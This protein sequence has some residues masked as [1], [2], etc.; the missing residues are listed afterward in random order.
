MFNS[1]DNKSFKIKDKTINIRNGNYGPYIQIVSL[2]KTQNISIPH[3]YNL[4]TITIDD[5]MQ[6]IANKNNIIKNKK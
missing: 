1:H 2:N 5:I 4:E 6:I 3:K